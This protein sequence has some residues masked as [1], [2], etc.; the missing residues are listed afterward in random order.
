VHMTLTDF[1]R[2][3]ADWL[4]IEPDDSEIGLGDTRRSVAQVA[5]EFVPGAIRESTPHGGSLVKSRVAATRAISRGSTTDR[6]IAELRR[7]VFD[8]RAGLD[9]EHDA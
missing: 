5:V 6:E 8:L 4:G 2:R 1:G 3:F 7:L 9:Q